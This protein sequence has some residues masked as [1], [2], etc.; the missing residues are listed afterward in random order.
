MNLKQFAAACVAML[1]AAVA[2]VPAAAASQNVR[3]GSDSAGAALYVVDRAGDGTRTVKPLLPR[4]LR[5][6]AAPTPLAPTGDPVCGADA[7]A[8]EGQPMPPPEEGTW[9]SAESFSLVA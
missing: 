3:D 2:P 6:S 5:S 4:T 8:Y 1:A 7:V 9:A